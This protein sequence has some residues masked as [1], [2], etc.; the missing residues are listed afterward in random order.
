MRPLALS[1]WL[2]RHR[3]R[4]IPRPRRTVLGVNPFESRLVPAA[5]T[6]SV[7]QDLNSNGVRDAG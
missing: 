6:G 7:Y 2:Q 5:L 4:T 1:M 3:T